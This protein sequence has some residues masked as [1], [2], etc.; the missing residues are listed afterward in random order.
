M[1]TIFR[2]LKVFRNGHLL[3]KLFNYV[4]KALR[5]ILGLFLYYPPDYYYL[6][7]MYVIIA[8]PSLFDD[9]KHTVLE[10]GILD[11][12]SAHE[13]ASEYREDGRYTQILSEDEYRKKFG[14]APKAPDVFFFNDDCNEYED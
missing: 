12:S 5:E 11:R 10:H 6:Q 9:T 4:E 13:I 3:F 7:F 1:Y 2:C 14:K 8:H